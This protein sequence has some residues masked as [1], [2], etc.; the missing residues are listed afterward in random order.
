M[1]FTVTKEVGWEADDGREDLKPNLGVKK[2]YRL[3]LDFSRR[4]SK[5]KGGTSKAPPPESEAEEEDS[6]YLNEDANFHPR[7]HYCYN[8]EALR[9]A[10]YHQDFPLRGGKPP[11]PSLCAHCRFHRKSRLAN[12]SQH[13]RRRRRASDPEPRGD[14]REWCANCGTLR[15]N[16]YHDKL[17]SGKVAPWHEVCGRCVINM[18]K[19]KNRD[20]LWYYELAAAGRGE[21]D[22]DDP[23]RDSLQHRRSSPYVFTPVS[24]RDGSNVVSAATSASGPRNGFEQA[25]DPKHGISPLATTRAR[26]GMSGPSPSTSRAPERPQ[27]NNIRKVTVENPT[28]EDDRSHVPRSGQVRRRGREAQQ[29]QQQA[30]SREAP[31]RPAM[32]GN[33]KR[34]EAY[35]QPRRQQPS[36][37]THGRP[38]NTQAREESRRA[39]ASSSRGSVELPQE[40]RELR[41]YF[42]PPH[43]E[44]HFKRQ[45]QPKTRPHEPRHKPVP[46]PT[47]TATP[48]SPQKQEPY[49]TRDYFRLPNPKRP[50]Q[51]GEK[52]AT[53][54]EPKQRHEPGESRERQSTRHNHRKRVSMSS[55]QSP[56]AP[57]AEPVYF[58]CPLPASAQAQKP[59]PKPKPDPRPTHPANPLPNRRKPDSESKTRPEQSQ[60][61]Q[62]QQQKEQQPHKEKPSRPM[63]ISDMYWSSEHGRAEQTFTAAGIFFPDAAHDGGVTRD[64]ADPCHPGTNTPTGGNGS[65]SDKSSNNSGN[66][67]NGSRDGNRTRNRSSSHNDTDNNT[68]CPP[69][70]TTDE[71]ARTMPMPDFGHVFRASMGHMATAEPAGFEKDDYC[72]QIWE[73]DSDEA[74]EIEEGR[75]RLLGEDEDGVNK[76]C[77]GRG[78]RK[79]WS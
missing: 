6:I 56:V 75:A 25:K 16:K 9:S 8:C 62:Q 44:E 65:N 53:A 72:N 68:H 29:P 14:E 52:P 27:A 23:L 46:A 74:E 76:D 13:G 15:S 67:R 42:R 30:K 32:S 24:S 1:H 38:K 22:R 41:D 59:K 10:Q 64:A 49:E 4:S 48:S 11:R 20:R 50:L 51:P 73:V 77:Y 47:P 79:G 36:K 39:A 61:R 60:P 26:E 18:V 43:L 7:H 57:A 35:E 3:I 37:P 28:S 19:K 31:P 17:L 71:P 34:K 33:T 58:K 66:D 12:E 78:V 5:A 54:P 69:T 70:P 40:G 45:T 63:G 2:R 21:E 55:M